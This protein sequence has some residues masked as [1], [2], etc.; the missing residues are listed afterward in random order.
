[1]FDFAHSLAPRRIAPIFAA[2][3][4]LAIGVANNAH[5]ASTTNLNLYSTG[6]QTVWSSATQTAYAAGSNDTQWSIASLPS[7]SAANALAT[8]PN[9]G[10]VANSSTSNWISDIADNTGQTGSA[11]GAYDYR[12]SFIIPATVVLS[13]VQIQFTF[14]ADDTVSSVLFDGASTGIS[15]GTYGSTSATQTI[16]SANAAFTYGTNRIDFVTSNT[17]GPQG[18]KVSFTSATGTGVAPEP[19]A[20]TLTALG[21]LPLIGFLRSARRRKNG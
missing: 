7:G 6:E 11:A 10:W 4:A 5:A 9:T 16:S 14:A 15:G 17:G 3:G 13:T 19:G 20:L 8:T 1:M 2:A 12:T 18:L 21:A